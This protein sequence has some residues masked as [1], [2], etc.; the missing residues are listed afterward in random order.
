[1]STARLAA[2]PVPREAMV[3]AGMEASAAALAV[4]YGVALHRLLP[5][6]FHVLTNPV[7]AVALIGLARAAGVRRA[8]QGLEPGRI[9]TGVAAGL[10]AAVPVVGAIGAA[11]AVPMTRELFRDE[12]L[13]PLTLRQAL[14]EAAVRIPVAT[15][16]GEEVVF[17]GALLGVLLRRH[18]PATAA[19]LSSALFGL[20]HLLPGS[21]ILDTGPAARVTANHVPAKGSALTYAPAAA[22]VLA[23]AAAGWALAELRLRTGSVVAPTVAH[24][25]LNGAA[26]LA[27]WLVSRHP[28]A[29]DATPA[30]ATP[31]IALAPSA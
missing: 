7:A 8:G 17:R 22:T 25:A 28:R 10:A 6:R 31:V 2:G 15:A 21:A 26:L 14:Y 16:L 23:T 11:L 1:V 20:W 12:R 5:R 9:L 18:P 29:V 30:K 13:S 4:G 24:A 3:S 27:G 19:A